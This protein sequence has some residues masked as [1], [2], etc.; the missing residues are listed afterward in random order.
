MNGSY[1]RW[2]SYGRERSPRKQ[3]AL[4]LHHA[5]AQ[6][7]IVSLLKEIESSV[8]VMDI[9]CGDGFFL[10][11]LLRMGFTRVRGIDPGRSMVDRCLE[12]GLPAARGSLEEL[13]G[14]NLYD[15]VLL[16][17]VLEHL[18]DPAAALEKIKVLLRPGGKLLLTVPVC[19]SLLKRYHRRRYGVKKIEQV[20]DWDE[21]HLH[22]FSGN[23]IVKMAT[24]LDFRVERC[25][26]A[27][28]PFPWA[29]R[30]GGK[31]ISEFFQRLDFGGRF[32]D[33]L[34]VLASTPHE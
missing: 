19:D 30:Y 28:N 3:R 31:R 2:D 10:D 27:S 17:E 13:S 20:T 26:H 33:I 22:A 12:R 24:S 32:G 15:L 5:L 23:E 11:L 8:Q 9:G 4:H 29:G 18:D 25:L 14:E 7:K 6:K 1:E 34:I 21:T 16:I